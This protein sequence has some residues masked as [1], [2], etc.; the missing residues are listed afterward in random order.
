MCI[1]DRDFDQLLRDRTR[2]G[3][4]CALFPS[5]YKRT[6]DRHRVDARVLEKSLVLGSD[7][8]VD[9]HIRYIGILDERTPCLLYTSSAPFSSAMN[10]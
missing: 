4:H 6:A 10:P 7:E 1:R 9:H 2:T 8:R 3:A 5:V